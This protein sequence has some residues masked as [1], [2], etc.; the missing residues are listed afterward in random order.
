[1]A[2]RNSKKTVI[3]RSPLCFQPLRNFIDYAP[4]APVTLLAEI[5]AVHIRFLPAVE[6]ECNLHVSPFDGY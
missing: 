5:E 6:F 1:L 4:E 3:K 2:R